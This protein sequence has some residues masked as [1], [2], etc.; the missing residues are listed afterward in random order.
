MTGR[1]SQVY[2]SGLDEVDRVMILNG[3]NMYIV[4]VLN[5]YILLYIIIYNNSIIQVLN[6]PKTLN[7]VRA[8]PRH[9]IVQVVLGSAHG[10]RKT[11]LSYL[12]K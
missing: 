12:N 9:G 5:Y 3:M 11:F 4:Y 10:L 2:V 1:F 8:F 7:F 6:N